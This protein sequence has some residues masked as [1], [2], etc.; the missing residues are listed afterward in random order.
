MNADAAS[1]SGGDKGIS[2]GEIEKTDRS[3]ESVM[4]AVDEMAFNNPE[5]HWTDV[6]YNSDQIRV[7]D[8]EDQV[9]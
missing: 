5:M 9:A 3:K 1:N 7:V 8:L 6:C 2:G 4:N